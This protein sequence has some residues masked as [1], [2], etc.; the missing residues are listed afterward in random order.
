MANLL[1][2]SGATLS[3]FNGSTL[4]FMKVSTT[5]TAMTAEYNSST[6]NFFACVE[7]VICN[8]PGLCSGSSVVPTSGQIWPRG[9]GQY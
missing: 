8:D 4:D 9:V 1:G 7:I 3:F 6:L 2:C 5:V